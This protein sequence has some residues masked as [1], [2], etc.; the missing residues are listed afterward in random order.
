MMQARKK[1]SGLAKAEVQVVCVP[2]FTGMT[3]DQAKAAIEKTKGLHFDNALPADGGTVMDQNPKPFHYFPIGT[4]VTLQLQPP[5]PVSHLRQV[6]DITHLD[7][8]KVEGFLKH[9]GLAYGGSSNTETNDYPVGTIFQDPPERQWVEEN[10]PV[11]RHQAAAPPQ[12]STKYQLS[13]RASATELSINERVSFEA[14]LTPPVAGAG[15]AFDF[16]DGPGGDLDGSKT[17]A[18][19]YTRDGTFTITVTAVLPSGESLQAQTTVQVHAN[20]WTIVLQPNLR[21]AKTN[22]PILFEAT[23][24]PSSPAPE[25]ARYW[26]YFD[27]DEKPVISNLPSARRSFSDARTHWAS[28]VVKDTDGHSFRSNV[29]AVVIVRPLWPSVVGAFAAI[30][31]LALGVLTIAQKIATGRL[32]YDWVADVRG[33][34]LVTT[35]PGGVVDAGFEFRVV[36]SPLDVSTHCAGRIIKRVE[37]SV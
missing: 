34:Q 2:D 3:L 13:L 19:Q 31:I 28:V 35:V 9:A 36:H 23:L 37:R 5:E 14:L 8:S 22:T 32:K 6:P 17:A 29:A 7:E 20:S 15:Y 30:A 16:G 26:F 18:N 33:T 10:T 27:N 21:R 12:Q 1:P 24:L 4:G 11:F 25:Q